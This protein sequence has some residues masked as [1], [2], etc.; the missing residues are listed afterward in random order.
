[1][2]SLEAAEHNYPPIVD[3]YFDRS[4]LE[5]VDSQEAVLMSSAA[6][7]EAPMKDRHDALE[8]AGSCIDH[9]ERSP[10][11]REPAGLAVRRNRD[12][13][14]DSHNYPPIVDE[15]F[16]RSHLEFVDSQEAVPHLDKW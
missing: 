11:T 6:I 4:H 13:S 10:Q 7:A 14:N 3:E 5:F 12:V 8:T 9:R 15:Y 2:E 16:D 1:M